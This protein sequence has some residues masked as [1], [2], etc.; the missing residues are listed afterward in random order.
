MNLLQHRL[1]APSALTNKNLNLPRLGIYCC[2]VSLKSE[3]E[4]AAEE[5]SLVGPHIV[6]HPMVLYVNMLLVAS[7]TVRVIM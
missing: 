6:G 2:V 1:R 7:S 5:N 4:R 3:R